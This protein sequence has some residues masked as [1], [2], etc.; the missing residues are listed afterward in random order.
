M[1]DA[2]RIRKAIRALVLDPDDRVLLVRL[3][4]PDSTVWVT[5]GGG[6]EQNET[7]HDTLIRE[8]D[9]ETGLRNAEIGPEIWTRTHLFPFLSGLW[10]GQ[11]ER[12]YLV[13]TEAF[14]P[15]PRLSWE[16]LSL[17]YMTAIRWWTLDELR[18]AEVEFGPTRLPELVTRL[19]EEGPPDSPIDTGV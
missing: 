16:E 17:E 10:D 11:S 13:R 2:P 6:L 4:F 5:P 8:L 7:P 3:D 19:V 18:E 12:F 9:E 1:T 15:Q 14:D